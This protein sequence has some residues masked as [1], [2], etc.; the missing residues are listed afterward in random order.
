MLVLG[1]IPLGLVS[2]RK[3]LHESEG[4]VGDLAP[5]VERELHREVER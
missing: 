3:A 4:L 1:R 2:A 5:P